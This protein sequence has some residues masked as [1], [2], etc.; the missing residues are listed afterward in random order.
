MRKI[1]SDTV[2]K[3]AVPTMLYLPN[4]KPKEV[5]LLIEKPLD[6]EQGMT[7]IFTLDAEGKD[8]VRI[9]S[10]GGAL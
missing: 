7:V 8:R 2:Y 1:N 6:P 5:I 9:S 3:L 10:R 4:D